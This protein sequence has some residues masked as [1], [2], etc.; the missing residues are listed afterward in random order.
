M[1]LTKEKKAEL[2]K[3]F[4]K[5]EKDTGSA[6]VQVA[7]MTE[8]IRELTVHMKANPKD[9]SSQRGLMILVGRR[10]NL[11]DYLA[12]KDRDAY[13]KLIAELGLRK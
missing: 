12:I 6:E 9:H 2:V 7:L 10:R 1:A 13:L 4:G 5:D 3:T 8:Q 11:L